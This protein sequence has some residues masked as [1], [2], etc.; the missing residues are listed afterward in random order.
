MPLIH[1]GACF[2]YV[3]LSV[4]IV[5]GTHVVPHEHIYVAINIKRTIEGL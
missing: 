5:L 4:V 3:T 2:I 1:L